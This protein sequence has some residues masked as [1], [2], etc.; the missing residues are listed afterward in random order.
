MHSD[1]PDLFYNCTDNNHNTVASG[2]HLDDLIVLATS[3][4]SVLFYFKS[5]RK[6]FQFGIY[7]SLLVMHVLF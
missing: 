6:S 4:S 1:H 2:G 3:R 5:T 7:I